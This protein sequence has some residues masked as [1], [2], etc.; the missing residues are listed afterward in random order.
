MSDR[1]SCT[2][3]GGI[4]DVR[5]TRPEKRNALDREMFRAILAAAAQVAADPSV[6]AVVLSGEGKGFCAGLD[7][8][9]FA[10]MAESEETQRSLPATARVGTGGRSEVDQLEQV[11]S[12]RIDAP[13]AVRVWTELRAPVIAAVHGV[14]VGGGFQ[15]ALGADI[16]I[17]APD[18]QLGAFEIRWGIVPDMCG[19]QLLPPLVGPDV[20]K[21]LMF[22]GRAVSG[23]EALRIGLATRV[24]EEPR[25][26]ALELAAE[27]A[28]RSPAAI[29]VI[30]QLVD[31]SWGTTLDDGLRAEFELTEGMIGTAN[32]LEAVRANLEQRPGSFSD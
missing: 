12:I 9:L 23:D 13:R 27:I 17:V 24:A 25:A 22:T 2:I 1:V 21:D 14:A 8:S 5:L 26:A 28:G 16:R 18:A 7:M 32:Q 6:R 4:A 31:R 20:A 3:E 11:S 10:A 15:L 29:R 30:K 19:T